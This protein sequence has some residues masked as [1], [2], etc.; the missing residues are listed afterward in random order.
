VAVLFTWD[1]K[2]AATNLRKHKVSFDEAKTVFL[3][4]FAL[5]FDDPDHSVSERRSITIGASN[6]HRV[7]FVSHVDNLEDRIRLVSARTATAAERYAYQE[8]EA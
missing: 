4:P 7:L 5:T 6:Y 1:P 2:K 8:F 3:D